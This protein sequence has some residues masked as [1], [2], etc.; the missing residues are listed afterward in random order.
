MVAGRSMNNQ[1]AKPGTGTPLPTNHPRRGMM[2]MSVAAIQIID[3]VS[4]P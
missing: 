4:N 1:N 3:P 2:S